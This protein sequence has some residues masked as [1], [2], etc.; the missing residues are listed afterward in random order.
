MKLSEHDYLRRQ[1]SFVF[2]KQSKT[3]RGF[4]VSVERTESFPAWKSWQDIPASGE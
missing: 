4:N 2:E 1:S 3:E